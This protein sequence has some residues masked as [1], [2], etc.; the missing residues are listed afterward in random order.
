LSAEG[1]I[2]INYSTVTTVIADSH[3]IA[4]AVWLS[5]AALNKCYC[6]QINSQQD[7]YLPNSSLCIRMFRAVQYRYKKNLPT[8]RISS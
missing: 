2:F 5:V 7:S 1:E 4:D 8:A 3:S 6:R